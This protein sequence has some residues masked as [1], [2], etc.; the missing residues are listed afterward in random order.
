[1]PFFDYL[2]LASLI[3]VVLFIVA[4]LVFIAV[5]VSGLSKAHKKFE[6]FSG[7][8]ELAELRRRAKLCSLDGTLLGSVFK[9]P[10]EM[11]AWDK[12]GQ[13]GNGDLRAITAWLKQNV[14][15]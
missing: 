9:T 4:V 15:K 11:Q 5:L 12:A 10:D 3:L 6:V 8:L 2:P 14:R 7:T 13:P 1:M